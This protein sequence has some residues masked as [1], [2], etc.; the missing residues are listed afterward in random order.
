MNSKQ[1]I[2]ELAG[3]V[4]ALFEEQRDG[5]VPEDFIAVARELGFNLSCAPIRGE[6]EE[7]EYTYHSEKQPG[8]GFWAAAPGAGDISEAMVWVAKHK[9]GESR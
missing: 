5:F 8:D 4:R 6:R 2:E 9:K 7:V 3:M 1:D